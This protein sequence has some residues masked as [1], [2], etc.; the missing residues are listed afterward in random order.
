MQYFYKSVIADL[1]NKNFYKECDCCRKRV[2]ADK[3]PLLC[4][5]TKTMKKL[6]K[7]KGDLIRQRMFNHK[8][9][10]AV[11]HLARHFNQCTTCGKW[12][13]NN[14]YQIDISDGVCSGCFTVESQ[15]EFNIYGRKTTIYKEKL[16]DRTAVI[17]TLLQ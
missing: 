17:P 6:E 1:H 12:V 3:V 5:G 7:G 14:C 2:Y 16:P 9:A 4:R 15:G 13:C 11:Q 8:K 10:L